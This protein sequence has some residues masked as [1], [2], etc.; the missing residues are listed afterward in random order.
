MT[1]TLKSCSY[2]E[3]VHTVEFLQ[4]MELG[5]SVFYRGIILKNT[6]VIVSTVLV[7]I[8]L[9]INILW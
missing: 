4:N 9:V 5:L 3:F 1:T 8:L 7:H 6:P 2:L